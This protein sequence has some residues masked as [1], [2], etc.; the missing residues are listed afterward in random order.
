[1]SQEENIQS[2][3]IEKFPYLSDKVVVKRERRIFVDVVYEKFAEVFD[4]VVNTLEFKMVCTI[5][6]LDEGEMFGFVY[7]LSKEGKIVLN[8]KTQVPKTKPVIRTI[9]DVFPFTDIYEREL[10]DLFGVKVEGLKP[11]RRYP[12]PDN[13][14]EGQY[15]LRKD[16][17]N[18]GYVKNMEAQ[19][20]Q[21]K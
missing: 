9:S 8:L 4:Y 21:Q 1:M 11:G 13:W 5:T 2:R 19:N 16:W 10:E 3:L 18:G 7:H 15:P 6:G 20:E 12:L 17:K 14:P